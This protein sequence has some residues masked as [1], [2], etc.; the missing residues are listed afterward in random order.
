MVTMLCVV[1]DIL[2]KVTLSTN[3]TGHML[4]VITDILLFVFNVIFNNMS[5]ITDNMVTRFTGA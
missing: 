3:K 4:N 5:V 1:A 2:L